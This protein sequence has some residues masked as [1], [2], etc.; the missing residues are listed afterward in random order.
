[1]KI[2]GTSYF[3]KPAEAIQFLEQWS[4]DIQQLN[5]SYYERLSVNTSLGKTNVW[6]YNC[7]DIE[8][9]VLVFFP[10]ARTC[11]LFWDMNNTL[12]SFKRDYRIFLVDVNGHPNLSEGNNPFVKDEGYGVWATEVLNELRISKATIVGA[13]LG[14]LICLKLCLTSPQLVSKAILMNPAGIRSF[15]GTVNN[16]Y[17][18]FL[19]ILFP[20]HKTVNTFFSKVVF[21]SPSHILPAS[22]RQLMVDY[23]LYVLKNHRFGGDYPAPLSQLE[24]QHISTD[25]HLIVGEKDILFPCNGT[26]RIAKENIA[27]LKSISIIQNTGHGIETSKAAISAVA[28][29]L[30][31]NTVM[32]NR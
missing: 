18:N 25:I 9:E 2:K 11:G 8:K 27:L 10:G 16:L 4:V 7:R 28:A 29:I 32:R 21:C 12:A 23:M 3:K 13:S 6:A 26:I 19:P 20:S 24:L 22:Y 1:M 30:K 31:S 15:S 17:Y 5:N 14:G